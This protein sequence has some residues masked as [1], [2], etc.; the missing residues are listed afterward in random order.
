M[1]LKNERITS[2]EDATISVV[3]LDDVFQC[4]CLEDENR[5]EKVV[6]ET[7]IP[8]GKYKIGVRV[9][10]GFHNRYSRK[11]SDIHQGMLHVQDVPSVEFI[12]WYC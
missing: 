7:R 5:E 6:S 1:N 12:S 10:G 11:Y 9:T 4:F 2:D 3:Y 8:A